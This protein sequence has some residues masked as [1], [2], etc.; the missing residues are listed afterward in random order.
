MSN[1]AND[2]IIMDIAEAVCD[3]LYD[4]ATEKFGE[5]NDAASE[6][7]ELPEINGCFDRRVEEL[8]QG[9]PEGPL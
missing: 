4:L 7:C 8:W 5:Y 9:Y 6:W 3:E 2:R 1:E